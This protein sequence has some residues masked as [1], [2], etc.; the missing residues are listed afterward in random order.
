MAWLISQRNSS[1]SEL[2]ETKR[3]EIACMPGRRQEASCT[4][5]CDLL[6]RSRR[7]GSFVF[8]DILIHAHGICRSEM[9]AGPGISDI[10]VARGWLRLDG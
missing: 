5:I 1:P 6:Q 4:H 9:A 7:I 10:E 2:G 8:D 3:S